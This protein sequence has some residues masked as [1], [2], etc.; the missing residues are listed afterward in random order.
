MKNM[1]EL[2]DAVTDGINV[3]G[4]NPT[5]F[6]KLMSKQHRSLQATFTRLCIQWLKTCEEMLVNQ[7]YDDRNRFE[8]VT[9]AYL[10]KLLPYFVYGDM[11]PSIATSCGNLSIEAFAEYDEEDNLIETGWDIYLNEQ[12]CATVKV[13]V[14]GKIT[15]LAKKAD[16]YIINEVVFEEED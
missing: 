10:S 16:G 7:K 14:D 11:N 9:A 5:E 4:F 3:L 13:T 12:D 1:K 15:V 8:V 6:C 2:V